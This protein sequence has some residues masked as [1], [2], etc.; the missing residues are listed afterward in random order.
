MDHTPGQRQFVA[1]EKYREYNQGKYGLSDAQ[2]AA[3]ID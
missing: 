2:M 1:V 3:L